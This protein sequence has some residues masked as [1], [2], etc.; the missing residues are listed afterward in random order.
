MASRKLKVILITLCFGRLSVAIVE[1]CV[2]GVKIYLAVLCMVE[3]GD[4]REYTRQWPGVGVR[5][6]CMPRGGETGVIPQ[7]L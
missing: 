1:S 5:A 4:L 3:E 2:D 6:K 7:S